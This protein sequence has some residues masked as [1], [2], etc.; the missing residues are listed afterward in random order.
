MRLR[1]LSV[2]GP[3]LIVAGVLALL[4]GFWLFGRLTN[5]HVDVLAYWLPR[6]CYLGKSLAHGPPG[7][8]PRPGLGAWCR[9]MVTRYP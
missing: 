4:H 3:V 5:Q 7:T 6:W 8:T 1:G 2:A 9:H